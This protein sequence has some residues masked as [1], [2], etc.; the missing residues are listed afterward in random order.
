MSEAWIVP[1]GHARIGIEGVLDFDSV[2]TL[3]R[4]SRRY[5][6]EKERL[7]VD[8]DGVRR[9]NSA[10]LA[11]VIEWIELARRQGVS[12]RFRNLPES[13]KRLALVAGVSDLLPVIEG[14]DYHEIREASSLS[15]PLGEGRG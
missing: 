13:L 1:R 2:V 7:D 10:G 14:G 4:E 12:L 5:F 3:L 15:F 9:A 8:L 11:L 6:A